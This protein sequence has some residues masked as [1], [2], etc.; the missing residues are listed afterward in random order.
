MNF[1]RGLETLVRDRQ[2]T[3]PIRSGHQIMASES[4][5]DDEEGIYYSSLNLS[6]YY[7]SIIY[8]SI[9]LLSIFMGRQSNIFQTSP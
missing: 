3:L 2:R 8:L 6:I 4:S 5:R 7:L 9:Y 1:L